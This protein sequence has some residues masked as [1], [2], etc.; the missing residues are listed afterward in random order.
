MFQ[1]SRRSRSSTEYR[2]LR[3]QS[4]DIDNIVIP[5]SVAASTRPEILNYKE[6]ITP[7]YDFILFFLFF[8]PRFNTL[9]Q[10]IVRQEIEF[11]VSAQ[12]TICVYWWNNAVRVTVYYL[13]GE[14]KIMC[15][16][17]LGSNPQSSRY[18]K[19]LLRCRATT[20]RCF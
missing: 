6:I 10:N 17:E 3:R 14:M 16:P 15:C 13:I 1:I 9:I 11:S 8:S 18:S 5:Q 12:E 4:Y 2:A 20:T 7:K 19:M